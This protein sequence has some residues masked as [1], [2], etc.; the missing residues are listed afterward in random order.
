MSWSLVKEQALA[1]PVPGEER[2]L[3]GIWQGAPGPG[4]GVVAPPHPLM[5]G[6]MA[7]PVVH[8]IAYAL[9]RRGVPSLRFDW[10]GVGGSSGC[11]TDSLD[12]AL[13]DFE[14]AFEHMAKT[15][16]GAV[17][18]AGYSFGAVVA[19]RAALRQRP[20]RGVLMVA[21]P[22]R[23]LADLDLSAW[24]GPLLIVVG[25]RDP[26][27][28]AEDLFAQVRD[29]PAAELRVIDGADHFFGESLGSLS[30]VLDVAWLQR[31][32]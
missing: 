3:D 24:Q 22:V 16:D 21:P 6:S 23:M 4:G 29:L 17:L 20:I 28:P 27:A 2:V 8:E 18:A 31:T 10:C 25:S 5:G 11:A 7:H 32:P 12:V 26:W 19:L 14:A 13:Q 1:I 30:E 9:H 15:V